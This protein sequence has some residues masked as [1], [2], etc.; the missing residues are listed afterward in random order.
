MFKISQIKISVCAFVFA[1]SISSATNQTSESK[2]DQ[3][4]LAPASSSEVNPKLN[5]EDASSA[6]KVR[7]KKIEELTDKDLEL[8][9]S[10]KDTNV[11]FNSCINQFNDFQSEK[12]EN[13][14]CRTLKK[15]KKKKRYYFRLL[16]CIIF[17]F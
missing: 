10:D 17:V 8:K 5:A 3:K 12:V 11:I 14:F 7:S 16:F 1:H 13:Q 2:P 9:W 4:N 6:E 15:L